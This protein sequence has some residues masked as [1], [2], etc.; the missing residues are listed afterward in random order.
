MEIGLFGGFNTLDDRSEENLRGNLTP[1][2]LAY[3]ERG[4][5]ILR[6]PA[7]PLPLGEGVRGVRQKFL[8]LN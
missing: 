4:R 5:K 3:K 2:P 8:I 7:P 1:Y 6:L